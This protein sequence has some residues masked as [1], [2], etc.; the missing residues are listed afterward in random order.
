MGSVLLRGKPL[1]RQAPEEIVRKGVSLVPERR[2][3]FAQ[4]TVEENLKVA[5]ASRKETHGIAQEI[6]EL[7]DRF[8]IL[9]ERRNSRGGNLSGGQ[10]QQLAIARALLTKPQLLLVDEP[11]LGLAPILIERVF[12]SLAELRDEGVSILL[13]EQNALATIEMSDRV[14]VL[15][16][17]KIALESDGTDA[18]I[19]AGMVKSY[20]DQLG[21]NMQPTSAP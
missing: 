2:R 13:V 21:L 20:I 14:Y 5:A 1:I 19:R 18:S 17:G 16:R 10:Q 9:G 4:L 7:Y 6:K 11:S 8:P 12:N 15:R 3:I